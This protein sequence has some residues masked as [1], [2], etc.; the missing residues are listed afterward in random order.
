MSLTCMQYNGSIT[1]GRETPGKYVST[2]ACTPINIMKSSICSYIV[3]IRIIC[4]LRSNVST[5]TIK[6][7]STSM[8]G[9]IHRMEN[10][11]TSGAIPPPLLHKP[12]DTQPSL[13]LE[14]SE[15]TRCVS[16]QP[17]QRSTGYNVS[18]SFC[19]FTCFAR[20]SGLAE[21]GILLRTCMELYN[22]HCIYIYLDT[23]NIASLVFG[24]LYL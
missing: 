13:F 5:S 11:K 15:M 24:S 1:G 2:F 12:G 18:F 3:F 4:G 7:R 8:L 16:V 10:I 14:F 19:Q 6:N 17:G 22:I 9:Q 23:L 20:L 21:V